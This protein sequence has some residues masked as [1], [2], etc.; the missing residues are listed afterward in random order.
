MHGWS[1]TNCNAA[2]RGNQN[3]TG[4]QAGRIGDVLAV[5]R[6]AN[7]LSSQYCD[8]AVPSKSYLVGAQ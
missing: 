7:Q 4:L 1:A 5:E 3:A 2:E 6:G 8:T